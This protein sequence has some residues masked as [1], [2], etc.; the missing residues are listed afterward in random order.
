M[1]IGNNYE[2]IRSILVQLGWIGNWLLRFH[3]PVSGFLSLAVLF[4]E[5]MVAWLLAAIYLAR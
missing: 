3:E 4:S 1:K 5:M 2:S